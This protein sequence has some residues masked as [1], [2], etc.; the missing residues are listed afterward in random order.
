ME[1]AFFMSIGGIDIGTIVDEKS[2]D[3]RERCCTQYGCTILGHC[4]DISTVDKK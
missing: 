3:L 2:N 1:H 4:M